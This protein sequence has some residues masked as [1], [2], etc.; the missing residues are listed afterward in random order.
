MELKG[1]FH[2]TF[3]DPEEFKTA[4]D[5]L[6]PLTVTENGKKKRKRCWAIF[7]DQYDQIVIQPSKSTQRLNILVLE[8]VQGLDKKIREDVRNFVK[9]TT[10]SMWCSYIFR[11]RLGKGFILGFEDPK[12]FIKAIDLFYPGRERCRAII[13]KNEGILVIQPTTS[14]PELNILILEKYA[15]I[16]AA[17]EIIRKETEGREKGP[18]TEALE[19]MKDLIFCDSVN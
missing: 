19:E 16:K 3:T 9:R 12:R 4:L 6:Y 1:R 11:D 10:D 8:D 7:P 5:K 17:E 14:T 18:V 13:P 2:L 15:E